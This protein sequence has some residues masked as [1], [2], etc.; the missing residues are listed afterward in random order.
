MHT[1]P[2]GR[3]LQYCMAYSLHSIH[4]VRLLIYIKMYCNV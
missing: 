2:S 1:K 3:Y 4:S